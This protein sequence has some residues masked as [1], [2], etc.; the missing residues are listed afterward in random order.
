MA[1]IFTPGT[2]TQ[3]VVDWV[4]DAVTPEKTRWYPAG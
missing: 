1:K 3:D 4:N 2:K